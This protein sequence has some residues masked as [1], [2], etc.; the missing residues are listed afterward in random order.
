[1]SLYPPCLP[2]AIL[3]ETTESVQRMRRF[4]ADPARRGFPFRACADV[5]ILGSMPTKP[6]TPL[7]T[8]L[9]ALFATL[10]VAALSLACAPAGNT[11]LSSGVPHGADGGISART[12]LL[13][14]SMAARMDLEAL[15]GQVIMTGIGA[16][17]YRADAS[18]LLSAYVAESLTDLKPGAVLLF[19][20]NV[21]TEAYRLSELSSL[22]AETAG[23]GASALSPLVAIDH[24]GGSVFR[25]KGGVT[26]LPAPASLG[27][28][29]I[30]RIHLYGEAS[31][32]ELRALGVTLVL[33]PVVELS[34][35]K[36]EGFLG[37]RSYGTEAAR[38]D[39]A[40]LAFIRGLQSRGVA[41]TAKHFPGN[42]AVDPHRGLPVLDLDENEY[43][44]EIL[45]RFASAIRGGAAAVML[46][47]AI[48]PAIDPERNATLS[49]ILIRDELKR[50]TG[51]DGVVITDDLYMAA[52]SAGA[53]ENAGSPASA[54]VAALA[55]GADMLML[56]ALGEAPKV[57]DAIA[58][59][60]RSGRLDSGRLRNA[61][62]RVIALK[63]RFG[64]VPSQGNGN[65]RIDAG[66]LKKIVAAY[67]AR[68]ADTAE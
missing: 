13:A 64:L 46:S 50:R 8:S 56:S 4:A 19:G 65:L 28:G 1:M 52:L 55:A 33:A 9:A 6:A 26:P 27:S 34:T 67:A 43:R 24:E 37:S 39:A 57:R 61:A 10:L 36:N 66:T 53:G 5:P 45:P 54:A 38:V 7:T 23:K 44:K 62:A 15:A 12:R 58:A 51:F 18:K 17:D 16:T 2:T 68:L 35:G 29:S 14:D 60:V 25:F 63:I 49:P 21:P 20:Y 30:E 40:A 59:A 42:G 48:L 47:H 32:T 22:L 11:G 41:A 3:P 31:G